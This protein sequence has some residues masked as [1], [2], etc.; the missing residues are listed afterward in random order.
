MV[1]LLATAQDTTEVLTDPEGDAVQQTVVGDLDEAPPSADLLSLHI[2]EVDRSLIL[3]VRHAGSEDEVTGADAVDTAIR[4]RYGTA[5][6]LAVI[7]EGADLWRTDEAGVAQRHVAELPGRRDGVSAWIEVPYNEVTDLQGTPL[8]ADARLQDIVV[9]S[10]AR[11]AV[12]GPDPEQGFFCCTAWWTL[13]DRMPQNTTGDYRI[14]SSELEPGLRL[15]SD[16]PIRASNGGGDRMVFMMDAE[17]TGT[18]PV[19]V[20]FAADEV[21]TGWNVTGPE[22]VLTLQPGDQERFPV[23]VETA[24]GHRHGGTERVQVR[25]TGDVEAT[26]TLGI[27]Y[28]TVAQPGGHHPQLLLHSQATEGGAIEDAGYAPGRLWMNTLEDD[29]MDEQVPVDST[30]SGFGGTESRWSVCLAEGQRLGLAL[31]Q[32]GTG[33]LEV[34]LSAQRPYGAVALQGTLYHYGPGA[35]VDCDAA[36]YRQEREE[37]VVAQIL[38]TAAQ[39]VQ[40]PTAFAAAVEP[41]IASVPQEDG[42]M[43][44]LDLVATFDVP[45]SQLPGPLLLE[46]G[47]RLGLPLERYEDPAADITLPTWERPDQEEGSVDADPETPSEPTPAAAWALLVALGAAA[48]V[49]RRRR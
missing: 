39:D 21:P 13:H 44:V 23:L 33:T 34:T 9:T 17:H 10:H 12:Q 14:T 18:A 45:D 8:Q 11:D 19:A 24:S 25:L 40:G 47:G 31:D 7:G 4:F 1:P 5:H 22:G 27:H 48:V 36:Q 26:A 15:W 49:L 41:A 46:P 3:D 16:T 2:A 35:P 32:N 43:L 38:E 42:A 30:E 20:R 6:Y 37:T 28:L 29:T